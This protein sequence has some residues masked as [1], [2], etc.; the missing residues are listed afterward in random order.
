MALR[1]LKSFFPTAD[2]LLQQDLPTLG[3]I[4][5][6]SYTHL[7]VYKRQDQDIFDAILMVI[8]PSGLTGEQVSEFTGIKETI[9][10][11]A[12]TRMWKMGCLLYTSEA[13]AFTVAFD[14]SDF[15]GLTTNGFVASSGAA[16]S[17]VVGELSKFPL[18]SLQWNL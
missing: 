1:P 12:L 18:Q 11:S 13:T 6:V 9:T 17:S 4:L 5:P 8:P 14:F 15:L 3:G 16:V 2:E 7:D 10:S